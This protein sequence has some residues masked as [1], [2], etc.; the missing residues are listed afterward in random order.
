M[1]KNYLFLL[2]SIAILSFSCDKER[3][4][5]YIIFMND[6][7]DIITS[8]ALN[9][10]INTTAT[11]YVESGFLSDGSIYY[12]RQ[13]DSSA[14]YDIAA[15]TPADIQ[16]QLASSV[17]ASDDLRGDEKAKKFIVEKATIK[18]SFD[19]SIVSPGS[20]VV[21]IVRD[22]ERLAKRLTYIV[23]QPVTP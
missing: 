1:K 23:K 6:S 9:V 14:M 20:K 19:E 7:G 11:L 2:V 5:S 17:E 12:E 16:V 15:V 3:N 4:H 18:T 22:G 21:I 10:D 13:I 8:D